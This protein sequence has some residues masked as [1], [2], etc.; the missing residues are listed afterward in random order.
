MRIDTVLRIV[1][2]FIIM[3]MLCSCSSDTKKPPVI[4]DGFSC[5]VVA[6]YE[7]KETEFKLR[8]EGA[9]I[10]VDY[11]S[12]EDLDGLNISVSPAGKFFTYEK[13]SNTLN[14][15]LLESS[16]I[17]AII[18]VLEYDYTSAIFKDNE[19]DCGEFS[20]SLFSDG[21]ISTINFY[22]L[23]CECYFNY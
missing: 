16:L 6:K 7:S 2:L 10:E 9:S 18:N 8:V 23:K 5:L 12:P 20:V 14:E 4:T 21:R 1:S 19:Y 13:I 15:D 11:L 17:G 22:E 3:F